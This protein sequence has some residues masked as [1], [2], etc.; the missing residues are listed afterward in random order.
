[1]DFSKEQLEKLHQTA[2]KQWAAIQDKERD[3]REEAIE[4]MR[5]TNVPGAQSEDSFDKRK[6]VYQG[7]VN[8]VAGLVD[9]VTGGQ[10][11][12]RS[13]IKYLPTGL[14]VDADSA[15]VKTG[16]ARNI[17]NMSDAQTAYDQ[18]FEESVTGG[19]GG[20][21]IFTE[22]MDD[23]FDLM[24][25]FRPIRSAASSL[26]FDVNAVD[27][28]K[29]DGKHAFLITGIHPD[30][31]EHEYPN[32]A[33]TDFPLETFGNGL[34]KGWFTQ[35]QMLIAEYWWKEQ[36][37]K[38][39]AQMTDGSVLDIEAEKQVMDDLA[40]KGITIAKG[41]GGKDKTRTFESYTVFMA[42]MNGA[43]FLSNPK[44]FPSKYIPLI[45]EYGRVAHIENET[46]TRG[47]I[48]FAKDPQRIYNYETSNQ[49]QIGAEVMDD[50][51]W[52][53][54]VQAKGHEEEYGNVK[55][56]RPPIMIF[57]PDPNNTGPPKRTGAP[58][59][60]QMAMSRIKQAEMDIYATTNMYPP[61][62]GLNVGLESGVA[63]KH[64]DEKGDRGS[65][66]F[67]DN[68]MKSI[69]HSA[70]V[71]EDIMTNIFDTERVMDVLNLDGTTE[72]VTINQLQ[73]DGYG[74]PVIDQKTGKE[75]MV[76]DLRTTFR[77]VVDVSKAYSTQKE[78]SL[79]QLIELINADE[80]FKMF[81]TDLI[82]KN[83]SILESDELYKRIRK[84]MIT[85]GT[86][87]P[88]DEETEELGLNQEKPIDPQTQ[89]LT[90]NIN[91]DTANKQANIELT[92]AK[93]DQV[94]ADNIKKAT[95]S[96][97]SLIEAYDKQVQAGVPLTADQE[98]T[99]LDALAMIEVE[100]SKIKPQ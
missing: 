32:A 77:T 28:T 31:F 60:Q 22:F 10:R 93:V 69:K 66:V 98:Q 97:K 18:S 11:E 82:A 72:T 5:F 27:Y 56:E 48:R 53:S 44:E 50:P 61:S 80:T 59:V 84:H 79:D 24:P 91:M 83:A 25:K 85:Q 4:D 63:L 94:I 33:K 40:L 26:F 54:S 35:D 92:D 15:N 1:M 88:T 43:E 75:V 45:P 9:Q 17:E 19:F 57:E 49:V 20:W 76:N 95:D 52:A 100:Q 30:L 78:E 65:Y 58:A 68:H 42:K 34:Y 46:Y 23:G 39:I 13:G 8:R 64:Q 71:L 16:I 89:A 96:Y 38:T 14:N 6:D 12:N 3:A 37:Q 29:K 70:E 99:K 90:D 7:E 36:K 55:I 86:A 51:V 67:V 74:K 2:L 62:L 81:S 21:G 47:L 73:K 87:D 41:R